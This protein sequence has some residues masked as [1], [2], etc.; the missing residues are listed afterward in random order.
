MHCV[1]INAWVQRRSVS[2]RLMVVGQRAEEVG[3]QRLVLA[4]ANAGVITFY[5]KVFLA[6]SRDL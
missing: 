6:L 4:A 5:I 2:R 1:V 3:V